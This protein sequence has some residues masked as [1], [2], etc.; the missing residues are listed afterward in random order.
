MID[1][2]YR[3]VMLSPR[4][5]SYNALP[6]RTW[7][8]EH[9]IYTHGIGV[10]LGPVNRVTREGLPELFIKD[11]PPVSD[12]DLT[13]K[14][15]EIYY[16]EMSNEYVFVGGRSPEFHYP[17]GDQ[18]VYTR[19]EGTGGVPLNFW[20]KFLFAIRFGSINILIAEELT[21]GSRIMYQRRVRER[22]AKVAPF[23]RLD[24][25]PYLVISDEGRLFWIVDGY[26]VTSRFP[27]SEPTGGLGNYVR[28]S[29]KAVLDAYNGS[30]RLY[31][32]DDKD[33][34]VMSYAAMF[35]G[36]FTPMQDMP[37]DIRNHIRY[38]QSMMT[39][40]ARMLRTYHMQNP[41]IF[42]N[43]ED[44]WA[45][46]MRQ[47]G[48]GQAQQEMEPYY[49]IM[50]IPGETKEEFIL[51]LP[52]TPTTR[53]NMSAWM[54]AR[55][56]GSQYGELIVYH[57]P[58]DRLVFGPQQIDARINQDTEIAQLMTLWSQGGSTVVRGSLLAIPI[59]QSILYVQ[60]VY[61]AAERGQLPE[62]KQVVVAHGNAITMD[63]TL[64]I[65]L[66]RLFGGQ[67]PRETEP[68]AEAVRRVT[69]KSDREAA[70]E[71]LRHYRRAQE[72]LRQN[73]WTGYGD[74]LRKMETILRSLEQR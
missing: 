58:K 21:P 17:M 72:M 16:G 5:L 1:G 57:F 38:P 40:Q 59:E 67:I 2:E 53:N 56:D 7:V 64:E 46:P 29:V 47:G 74:E 6:S 27:Y 41:Q 52:F 69:V 24:A 36:L 12:V 71:A 25:D 19:Y 18:N 30:V 45:I 61:L 4:E 60:P 20:R 49:T 15:P 62:L 70:L 8:N 13:V 32:S 65:S 43:K 66:K 31:I 23:I 55:C 48:L 3:Q 14:R 63:D 51:L 37:D 44:V 9:L 54:A 50:K 11:I 34:I 10:V 28:N 39:V 73:N 68:E 33:P 22:I 42:Y 26:T 35:P